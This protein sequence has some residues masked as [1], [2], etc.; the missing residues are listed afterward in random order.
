[1]SEN[2]SQFW[3][4]LL[5]PSGL[6]LATLAAYWN[7]F[8]VPFV[9]DDLQTIQRNAAVRFGEFNS[10]SAILFGTRE[11]LFK[12]FTLNSRWSGQ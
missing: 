3:P 7:S 6:I 2:K 11:I 10:L 12:T 9:F 1:M 4:S 5:V 8:C